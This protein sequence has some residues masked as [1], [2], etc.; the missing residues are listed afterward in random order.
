MSRRSLA[1]T[2]SLT[3]SMLSHELGTPFANIGDCITMMTNGLLRSA[4]RRVGPVTGCAM[5]ECYSLAYLMWPEDQTVLRPLDSPL[6]PQ[7]V[8]PEGAAVTNDALSR[9]K[10]MALRGTKDAGNFD[11]ILTGGR[12]ILV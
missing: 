3:G 7:S 10:F 5:L 6:I 11:Q 4:L 9:K 12:G 2:V 1:P 8:A